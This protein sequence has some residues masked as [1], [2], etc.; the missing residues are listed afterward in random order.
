VREHPQYDGTGHDV[1]LL[2]LQRASTL[3]KTIR[4]G[5]P[6]DLS[7]WEPGDPATI[8]GWGSEFSNGPSPNALKEATVPI[9]SDQSC[10]MSYALT[11]GIDP[12]TS[13]C[14]GELMGG[15]D[16][17]QGDSGGPLM[18]QDTGGAWIQVGA[19][20]FG[21]G[22]AFPTQYG[23]YAEAGG[24]ALRPWIEDNVKQ[25][26]SAG[27]LNANPATGIGGQSSTPTPSGGSTPFV[28]VLE[29]QKRA[30]ITIVSTKLGSASKARRSGHLRIALRAAARVRSVRVTL[31]RGGRTVATGTSKSFSG[32]K[33]LSLHV[34]R[35]LKAGRVTLRVQAIDA[36]GRKITASK[37]ARLTT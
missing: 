9:V 4:I 25:L 20:S 35:G 17:C 10:Q 28:P 26:S 21:L 34:R 29:P 37:T 18:V 32:S 16:S 22:C 31:R 5:G 1:A 23:V 15:E 2:K 19:T 7:Q 27:G 3:G 36:A 13:V 14:A 12:A 11:L 8:I 33:R 24:S 30:S 6:G